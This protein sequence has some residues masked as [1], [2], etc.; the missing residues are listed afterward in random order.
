MMAL[1]QYL[2]RIHSSCKVQTLPNVTTIIQAMGIG[3]SCMG[4]KQSLQW[5]NRICW[6]IVKIQVILQMREGLLTLHTFEGECRKS[7]KSGRT[8]F[9]KMYIQ[10][11]LFP[12]TSQLTIIWIAKIPFRRFVMR[13][14]LQVYFCDHT[15]SLVNSNMDSCSGIK[16]HLSDFCIG[17]ILQISSVISHISITCPLYQ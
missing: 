4:T 15:R 7:D 8:F 17:S 2:R 12:W 13:F 3:R 5:A 14:V 1:G 16:N 9:C 11:C 6:M 10:V